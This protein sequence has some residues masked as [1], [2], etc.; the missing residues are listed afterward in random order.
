[1]GKLS[2]KR[3]PKRVSRG[4]QHVSVHSKVEFKSKRVGR[5]SRKEKVTV[6]N[7]KDHQ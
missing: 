4:N 3:R 1:M 7:K 2:T 6:D 5:P